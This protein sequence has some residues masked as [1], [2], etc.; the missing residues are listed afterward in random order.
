MVKRKTVRW[1]LAKSLVWLNFL[2]RNFLCIQLHSTTKHVTLKLKFECTQKPAAP[3]LIQF[4]ASQLFTVVCCKSRKIC[5]ILTSKLFHT[6]SHGE[7]HLMKITW[8]V[9]KHKVNAISHT[10]PNCLHSQNFHLALLKHNSYYFRK[11]NKEQNT[12]GKC[13]I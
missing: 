13:I 12:N 11:S 2:F 7:L 9:S 8:I 4:S 6:R 1:R 10:F 5:C 3:E